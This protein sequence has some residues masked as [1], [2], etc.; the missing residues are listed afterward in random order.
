LTVVFPVPPN[1]LLYSGNPTDGSLPFGPGGPGGGASSCGEGDG[2][3]CWWCRNG[4]SGQLPTPGG[5][6]KNCYSTSDGIT[7]GGVKYPCAD[8]PEE[9]VVP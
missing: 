6:G 4:E 3:S 9:E 1:Y 5:V 2:G 7:V 8:E